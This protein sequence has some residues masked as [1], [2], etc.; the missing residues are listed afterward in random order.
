[1]KKIAFILI[2]AM[3]LTVAAFAKTSTSSPTKPTGFG[4][5]S[6]GGEKA[7]PVGDLLITPYSA[8]GTAPTNVAAQLRTAKADLDNY[9]FEELVTDFAKKWKKATGGAP[10]ENAVC[11]ALI[12]VTI[13][14]NRDAKFDGKS[15][16][17][18]TISVPG[19][20]AT[21]SVMVIAK[22]TGSWVEVDNISVGDGAIT[23][24]MPTIFAF[25][26]FA[27]LVDNGAV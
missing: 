7:P 25:A 12:D 17:T 14:G 21:D 10:V 18:F 11:F 23:I 22:H 4:L 19:L 13:T 9:S 16:I 24:T 8:V 1:M 26:D 27:I 15:P 3:L 6:V 20:S 5:I 2:V